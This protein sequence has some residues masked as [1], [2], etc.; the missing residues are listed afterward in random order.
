MKKYFLIA[1]LALS[2]SPVLVFAA[3]D[4]TPVKLDY[5]GFV[6]CDGVIDPKEPDRQT[7]CDFNAL[8]F[9]V[10]SLINWMFIITIPI[11]TVA[12][13]YG[14]LQYMSGQKGRIDNAKKIFSSIA[15]GF[16]IMLVAWF[17]VITVVNW[18]ISKENKD[19]INTFVN[20]TNGK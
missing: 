13:A 15:T 11:A 10:K 1:L 12:V 7:I 16:I 19:V 18:F 17:A 20:T 5:S 4:V 2:I 8:M 14:G 9:T 3:D 6:K